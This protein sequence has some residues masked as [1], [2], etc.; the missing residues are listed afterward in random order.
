MNENQPKLFTCRSCKVEKSS[1][2][3]RKDSRMLYGVDY[4]CV[5]CRKNRRRTNGEYLLERARKYQKR[6]GDSVMHITVNQLE[7]L[8][9]NHSCSYCGDPLTDKNSTL[10]HVFSLSQSYGGANIAGN[11]TQACRSCNSAKGTDHV[12]DFYRRSDNFTSTLW[13]AFVRSYTERLI[14]RAITDIEVEN[15]KR[16]LLDEAD[17]LQRNSKRKDEA[18]NE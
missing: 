3:F 2:E 9:T 15:M 10:D 17:E 7:S 1:I 11:L 13:T 18:A 5:D 14:G 4:E 16:N 6:K 8:L 12:A